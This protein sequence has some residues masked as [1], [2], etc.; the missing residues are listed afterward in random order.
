MK[1]LELI[2]HAMSVDKLV[3]TFQQAVTISGWCQTLFFLASL[4]SVPLPCRAVLRAVPR[5]VVFAPRA[6]LSQFVLV[7][8]KGVLPCCAPL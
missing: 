5:S 3:P 1:A 4:S 8:S 2:T 6:M 7:L